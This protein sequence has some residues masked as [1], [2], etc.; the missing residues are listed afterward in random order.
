MQQHIDENDSIIKKY[1]RKIDEMI[2]MIKENSD[3]DKEFQWSPVAM[4]YRKLEEE[5]K[6]SCEEKK[7][8]SSNELQTTASVST[9]DDQGLF[10]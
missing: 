10:L 6:R 5:E 7:R 3:K 2:Q 1:H 4:E 9:Q 8:I